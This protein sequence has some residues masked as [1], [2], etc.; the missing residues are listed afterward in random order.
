MKSKIIKEFKELGI[1]EIGGKKLEK[2]DFYTLCGFWKRIVKN[3]EE[4]K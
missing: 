2:Y 4:I 1:R 3:N